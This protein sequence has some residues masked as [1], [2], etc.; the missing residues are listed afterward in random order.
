M[1]DTAAAPPRD[2]PARRG[3]RSILAGSRASDVL[4]RLI[5]GDPLDLRRRVADALERRALVLDAERVF[6]RALACTARQAERYRGDPPLSA[7][8]E[9]RVDEALQ[10]L[11][12]EDQDAANEEPGSALDA[13]LCRP[14]GIEPRTA[15]RILYAFN[16][17]PL[18]ER[19]A[20]RDAV[21]VGRGLEGLGSEAL[22]AARRARAT[23]VALLDAEREAPVGAST[24]G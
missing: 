12:L 13:N 10:Q 3:W 23:L 14:L 7:W 22:P 21:I 15:G 1:P 16:S 2:P 17:R 8:L 18:A 24:S 4:R 6:L 19:R 5:A 9:R 11:V 20:F